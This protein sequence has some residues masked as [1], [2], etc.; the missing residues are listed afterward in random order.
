MSVPEHVKRSEWDTCAAQII[1][2]E[3]GGSVIRYE[4]PETQGMPGVSLLLGGLAGAA[5]D[6]GAA[7]RSELRLSY[8][9]EDLS[10]PHC[11]FLGGCS[12]R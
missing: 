6:Q 9:K 1:V 7:C 5:V 3:A 10:S 8:N 2:E 4:N 11:L 12:G